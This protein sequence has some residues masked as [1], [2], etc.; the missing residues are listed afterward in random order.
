MYENLVD[1]E[2]DDESKIVYDFYIDR[3]MTP[4]LRLLPPGVDK[5]T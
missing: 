1:R 5:G 3:P 4:E 2:I